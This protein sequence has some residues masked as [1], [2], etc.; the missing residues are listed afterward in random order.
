MCK[1]RPRKNKM[2]ELDDLIVE[3]NRSLAY[4]SEMHPEW[5]PIRR[6]YTEPRPFISDSKAGGFF[7]LSRY[8]K[9]GY[10]FQEVR[11]RL[12]ETCPKFKI[13]V[14]AGVDIHDIQWIALSW[15]CVKDL[16]SGVEM[17]C[18]FNRIEDL[19][20]SEILLHA[21]LFDC[22]F[23][24]AL[25]VAWTKDLWQLSRSEALLLLQDLRYWQNKW[26]DRKESL[27]FFVYLAGLEPSLV[28][29]LD[30]ISQCLSL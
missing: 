13:A 15:D 9:T 26:T 18:T 3:E 1:T 21:A 29:N 2:F 25:A 5:C 16:I 23:E 19:H 8:K 6:S 28:W 4:V 22:E 10:K 7:S 20:G 12:L 27:S 17:T 24:V 14:K 30:Y 11:D